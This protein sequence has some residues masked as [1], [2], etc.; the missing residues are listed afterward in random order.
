MSRRPL[1][2]SFKALL[3]VR[4]SE[5]PGGGV[6]RV[7]LIPATSAGTTV[8][9]GEVVVGAP[10]VDGAVVGG[11]VV[12]GAVVGGAVNGGAV[13]GVVVVGVLVV[14]D[15][16]HLGGINTLSSLKLLLVAEPS[17]SVRTAS[18]S[19]RTSGGGEQTESSSVRR[20][21][22]AGGPSK[23]TRNSAVPVLSTLASFTSTEVSNR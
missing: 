12:V 14:V 21:I 11:A 20:H 18:A 23:V 3:P 16:V 6:P 4:A 8:V 22:S 2:R 9:V 19:L 7:W 17:A 1:N 10:V 5:L 15:L 13:V